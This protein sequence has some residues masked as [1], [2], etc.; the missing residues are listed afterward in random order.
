VALG[1]CVYLCVYI[2]VCMC[3]CVCMGVFACVCV[4]SMQVECIAGREARVDG[5][6]TTLRSMDRLLST[7]LTEIDGVAGRGMFTYVTYIRLLSIGD[8]LKL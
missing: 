1:V 4:M 2:C 6:G 7:L 8:M 3:A 5:G